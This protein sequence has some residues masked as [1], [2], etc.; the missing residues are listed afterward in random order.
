LQPSKHRPTT[1]D[2]QADF[3]HPILPQPTTANTVA[4]RA[5][6]VRQTITGSQ[7]SNRF[8]WILVEPCWSRRHLVHLGFCDSHYNALWL[9]HLRRSITSSHPW[10]C[11]MTLLLRSR[12]IDVSFD[13]SNLQPGQ[14]GIELSAIGMT[15][16]V[17]IHSS[18]AS[19]Q[20]DTLLS[21]TSI[22]GSYYDVMWHAQRFLP[23]TWW[24]H[25]ISPELLPLGHSS[26][27]PSH[28]SNTMVG[29]SRSLIIFPSYLLFGLIFHCNRVSSGFGHQDWARICFFIYESSWSNCLHMGSGRRFR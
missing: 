17:D 19:H 2:F 10:P 23:H 18:I 4:I 27:R 25:H 12:S 16:Q 14:I 20:F 22:R 26:A 28:L 13:S 21:I 29:I 24:Q 8:Q 3:H 1:K 9:T 6:L 11:A 7:I 5:D 15:L